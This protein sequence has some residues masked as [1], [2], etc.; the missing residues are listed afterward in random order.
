MG[1]LNHLETMICKIVLP[2]KYLRVEQH[3]L[4]GSSGT[5]AGVAPHPKDSGKTQGYRAT[6]GGKSNVNRALFM[7]AM[8]ARRFNPT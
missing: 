5:L 4:C 3:G 7:A 2:A 6:R 8:A 1:G